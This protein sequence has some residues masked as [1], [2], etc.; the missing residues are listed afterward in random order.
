M[1]SEAFELG[2]VGKRVLSSMKEVIQLE[3]FLHT[4]LI[5]MLLDNILPF[6]L[7]KY[8]NGYD[9]KSAHNVMRYSG[10][11]QRVIMAVCYIPFILF[12]ILYS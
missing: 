9:H 2:I 8:Y 7:A 10:L 1:K 4:W 3:Y 6:I 11:W 5:V 12:T